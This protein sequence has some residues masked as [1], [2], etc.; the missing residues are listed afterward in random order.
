MSRTIVDWWSY[1]AR[2][3]VQANM[4]ALRSAYEPS[5]QRVQFE[6]RSSG[7]MGYPHSATV[8]VGDM[9]A[10]LLAWGGEQQRGWIHTSLSGAGCSW[11]VDWDHA[12]DAASGLPDYDVRRVDIALD[13]FEGAT[14]YDDMVSAYE[15]GGFTLSG[16]PPK[17]R[18]IEPCS[19]Y[20][21]RTFYVG[22]RENDKFFR[23]YEK[24][25]QQLA[26]VFAK[27][28]EDA[29]QESKDII[30]G[31]PMERLTATGQQTFKTGD[32]FRYELELK[33][34]SGPLPEDIIDRRD[35]YFAGAYPYLS[36]VLEGVESEPLIIPR[37]RSAQLD[38]AG[39]LEVIRQQYGRALFTALHAYEGDISAV[40]SRIV[41]KEH[42][43]RLVRAGV[44]MVEHY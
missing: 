39:T 13:S 3:D 2:G 34:K 37:E 41:G 44:L 5:G 24:G 23:G 11:V 4:Q 33:P 17:A 31:L 28:H 1:R 22:K 43:E 38:L 16:R 7:W 42:S 14:A 30:L 15:S 8:R 25:L 19:D 6:S 12:Q 35:Q 9:D 40:W 20:E 36:R 26:P 27:L 32:W 21:G 18:K 10:G 29:P